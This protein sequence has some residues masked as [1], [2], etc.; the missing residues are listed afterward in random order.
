MTYTSGS[1]SGVVV[2]ARTT[3][4]RREIV[5]APSVA[6]LSGTAIDAHSASNPPVIVQGRRRDVR[7]EA[8]P[9]GAS[10]TAAVTATANLTFTGPASHPAGLA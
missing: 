9:S 10:A 4:T 5:P 3:A 6:R 7:P 8:L 2:R 1:G